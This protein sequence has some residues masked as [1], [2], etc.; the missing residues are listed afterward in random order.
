MAR[1]VLIT[2]LFLLA[3]SGA[4]MASVDDMVSDFEAGKPIVKLTP[5]PK[6]EYLWATDLNGVRFIMVTQ[7]PEVDDCVPF[8]QYVCPAKSKCEGSAE[9]CLTKPAK[10]LRVPY[11][12]LSEPTKFVRH[13]VF[14][15]QRTW[16]FLANEI[17]E[18]YFP[19]YKRK[20]KL[21]LGSYEWTCEEDPNHCLELPVG[22]ERDNCLKSMPS[23]HAHGGC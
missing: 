13:H 6:D 14:R 11:H 22:K 7:W 10:C 23:C 3:L 4:T 8:D 9:S 20:L 19:P 12:V 21:L 18:A 5:M 17:S 2:I 1:K 16:N 15:E